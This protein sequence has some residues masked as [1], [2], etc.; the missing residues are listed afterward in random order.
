MNLPG[1]LRKYL[2]GEKEQ[3]PLLEKRHGKFFEIPSGPTRMGR[4]GCP[5]LGSRWK[6]GCH[7]VK[8]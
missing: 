3:P 6:P 5:L 7:H 4:I 1:S 2:K 8:I